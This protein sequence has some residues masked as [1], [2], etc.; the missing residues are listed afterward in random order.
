M[1]IK[2]AKDTITAYQD[3][4]QERGKQLPPTWHVDKFKQATRRKFSTM[5]I[6]TW[7][8]LIT[9]LAMAAGYIGRQPVTIESG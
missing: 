6:C 8:M 1:L 7:A 4:I 2:S 9:T 5:E 3:G